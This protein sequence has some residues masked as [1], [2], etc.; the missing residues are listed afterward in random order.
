MPA[1]GQQGENAMSPP[2][3]ARLHESHPANF[4]ENNSMDLAE[5][6]SRAHFNGNSGTRGMSTTADVV[7][8][9]LTALL[10]TKSAV[11]SE[12]TP[13][14]D[15]I[16]QSAHVDLLGKRSKRAIDIVGACAGLILSLPLMLVIAAIIKITSPGRV[17]FRQPRGG[18]NNE[19]FT[20]CKFRTMH[21]D[22]CDDLRQATSNDPRITRFGWFLRR[23]SCDELPQLFNVLR[24]DMS[25]V[26][27]RPHAVEHDE[28][29]SKFIENYPLR[30]AVLPGLTGW[31]QINGLRGETNTVEKMRRRV[32]YDIF[33][34]ENWSHAL[35]LKIIF[36]TILIVLWVPR[37]TPVARLDRLE[38]GRFDG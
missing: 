28:Q 1:K 18:L 8:N 26:G 12:S 19:A 13:S 24:G 23:T 6:N 9:N 15:S 5:T 22:M 17:I 27:P 21:A 30:Y 34:I 35:D 2:R 4:A 16:R 20:L 31:A 33:Y 37:K 10:E 25:L 29:Y 32:E 11:L 7:G 14:E 3:Q 36:R 38:S